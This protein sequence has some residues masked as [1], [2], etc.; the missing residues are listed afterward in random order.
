[1]RKAI[2]KIYVI[3][4]SGDIK[5]TTLYE[6]NFILYNNKQQP[7]KQFKNIGYRLS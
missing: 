2:K 1:M 6:G 3:F 4:P 5:Y 7:V